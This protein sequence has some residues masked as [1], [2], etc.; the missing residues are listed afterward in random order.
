[1]KRVQTDLSQGTFDLLVL[2]TLQAGPAH[3]W[4]IAHRIRQISR[5]LRRVGRGSSYPALDRQEA[6]GWIGSEWGASEHS[7]RAKFYKPTAAGRKR[8]AAETAS[9][10]RFTGAVGPILKTG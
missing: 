7:R 9:S 3:G 2:E 8:S 4:D 1:M 5:D 10:E 6:Q